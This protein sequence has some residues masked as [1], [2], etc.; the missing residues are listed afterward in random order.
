MFA[1]SDVSV[2]LKDALRNDTPEFLICQFSIHQFAYKLSTSLDTKFYLVSSVLTITA[3]KSKKFPPHE[4][5]PKIPVL[6]PWLVQVILLNSVNVK[7][8]PSSW[9]LIKIK[10]FDSNDSDVFYVEHSSG[11][12]NLTK[13][14]TCDILIF[15]KMSGALAREIITISY[16]ASPERQMMSVESTSDNQVIFIGFG[17]QD[18]IISFCL[19]DLTIPP[20]PI[21][22]LATLAQ[23]TI[24]SAAKR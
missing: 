16:V 15:T 19:N 20:N 3:G 21:T 18:A 1:S 6:L 23:G 7:Q 13:N 22:F 4:N 8:F 9:K 12:Q 24:K 17:R 5:L 10:P 2:S 14:N 11:E